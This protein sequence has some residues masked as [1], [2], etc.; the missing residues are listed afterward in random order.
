MCKFAEFGGPF[1]EWTL[2]A[3]VATLF[4]DQTLEYDPVVRK[5]VNLNAANE[6]VAL[7]YRKGWTL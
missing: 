7:E 4:P 3:N 6:A 1:T 2:L 5:V